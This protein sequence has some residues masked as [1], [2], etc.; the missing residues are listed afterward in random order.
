MMGK[1]LMTQDFQTLNINP[2]NTRMLKY[3]YFA[4]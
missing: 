2:Q 1:G 4:L 3:L